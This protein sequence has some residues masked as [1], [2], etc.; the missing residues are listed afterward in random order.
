MDSKKIQLFL[1][2]FAGGNSGSFNELIGLLDN[3]IEAAC[4]EYSGR[5]SRHKEVFITE[6]EDFLNDIANY[7]ISRF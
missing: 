1:L 4:V 2:T 7:L 6:Y 5:L 3:H